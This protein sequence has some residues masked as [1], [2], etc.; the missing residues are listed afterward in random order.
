MR[1]QVRVQVDVDGG[2]P[3]EEL[4]RSGDRLGAVEVTRTEGR[5]TGRVGRLELVRAN[6]DL[7]RSGP[8]GVEDLH[9]VELTL[10]LVRAEFDARGWKVDGVSAIL[11]ARP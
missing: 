2:I 4:I 6:Q 9:D 5:G 7:A 11:E 3:R 1:R 10:A 8:D